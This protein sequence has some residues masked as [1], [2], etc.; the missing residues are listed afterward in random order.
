MDYF[1]AYTGYR[2]LVEEVVVFVDWY[3][4][5]RGVVAKRRLHIHRED[6]RD[7]DGLTYTLKPDP[8]LTAKALGVLRRMLLIQNA[9][10]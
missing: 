10:Y 9:A 4:Q 6:R 1:P 7:A 2:G 5:R 3:S 8:I